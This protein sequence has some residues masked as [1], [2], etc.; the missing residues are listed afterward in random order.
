VPSYQAAYFSALQRYLRDPAPGLTVRSVL[1]KFP[2]VAMLDV[3]LPTTDGCSIDTTN[4]NCHRQV[5]NLRNLLLAFVLATPV[6][7]HAS[8]DSEAAFV[9]AFTKAFKSKDKEALVGFLYTKG[10]DPMAV[11]F[12]SMMLTESAG[13]EEVEINLVDLTPEEAKEASAPQEGPDGSMIAFPIKATKRL[14][15]ITEQDGGK[16][17]SKVYVA[18][19]DGKMV[20]PVPAPAP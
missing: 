20:I 9:E 3:H 16:A 10:A 14:V 12:Y 7:S 18:E 5:M 11:E 8:P 2:A 19:V 4:S 6:L 1:G 17:T 13:A 15:I